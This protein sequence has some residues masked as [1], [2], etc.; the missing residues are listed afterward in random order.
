MSGRDT[1]KRILSRLYEAAVWVPRRQLKE[2]ITGITDAKFEATLE[3]LRREGV[4]ARG[5]G[6]GGRISLTE[7]GIQIYL[8]DYDDSDSYPGLGDEKNLYPIVKG[9]L[10]A[11][12]GPHETML[13]ETGALKMRRG[14]WTNPDLMQISVIR[15]PILRQETIQVSSCEVKTWYD[16]SVKGVFEAAAHAAVFHRSWLVLEWAHALPWD[17][18]RFERWAERMLSECG[19]LGVGLMTLHPG[20]KAFRLRTHLPA[21]LGSPDEQ[22]TEAMVKYYLEKKGLLAAYDDLVDGNREESQGNDQDDDS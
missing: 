6:S 9:V 17:P 16:W 10:E 20:E 8:D 4:I 13:V 22:V 11:R 14:Q 12:S 21:K 1:R 5:R 3:E 7:L 18:A 2:K 15:R 19:R